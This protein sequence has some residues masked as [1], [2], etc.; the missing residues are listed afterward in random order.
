M[1]GIGALADIT[2]SDRFYIAAGPELLDGL[3][4]RAGAD[5]AVT[6]GG[7]FSIA[8]RAGLA[9]GVDASK[10][11]QGRKAFTIGIDFRLAFVHGGPAVLP[12]IALGYDSF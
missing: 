11:A 8:A 7:F 9:F 2:L 10:S 5:P 6:A 1:V 4:G 12:M 3:T